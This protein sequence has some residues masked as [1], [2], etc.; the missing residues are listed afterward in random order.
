[1][2]GRFMSNNSPSISVN[3]VSRGEPST[4]AVLES[5]AL[6]D[7]QVIETVLV[8]DRV[9]NDVSPSLASR[10]HTR[11]IAT[12]PSAGLLEARR[13]A[14]ESSTGDFVLLLDSTRLLTPNAVTELLD[15]LRTF[16]MGVVREDSVGEGYWARLAALD[17]AVTSSSNAM[18]EALREINGTALPRFFR[19]TTLRDAFRLLER[20]IGPSIFTKVVYGDHHL[21]FE[22]AT[23]ASRSVGVLDRPGFRPHAG[24]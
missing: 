9:L 3:L 21:I 6:Q 22:A 7:S 12:A 10:S 13:V 1:M 18:D 2:D 23:R 14:C 16:D 20:T 11:I 15:K 5:I 4:V 8:T 19:T 24:A 17:K